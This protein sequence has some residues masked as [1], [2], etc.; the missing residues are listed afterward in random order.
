ML[1]RALEFVANAVAR[2]GQIL[3]VG[4][5]RQAQEVVV[6]E[7]K[8]S[9]QFHVTGRWL[10]GTL[11]NFRTMKTGIERL[12][13]LEQM[14]QDGT[15]D[16]L[17]KKEALGLRRERDRLEKFVGGIKD[18]TSMPAALFVIDPNH[19]HIA[20]REANRLAIPVIALTDTNC[21]PD[22]V[23]YIIPGNDDAIRSVKLVAAAVADACLFGQGRRRDFM[24]VAPRR[25][26]EGGGPQVEFS[27]AVRGQRPDFSASPA[28][29]EEPGSSE[30]ER[31]FLPRKP[32][33]RQIYPT[34]SLV[35]RRPN[36]LRSPARFNAA[37][38]S[39]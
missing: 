38:I 25:G 33:L 7:A 10:G 11:T 35:K 2:G 29:D 32:S 16:T 30:L 27:R 28:R 34:W 9:A 39:V 31:G 18:M 8:R 37:A 20:V 24:H 36:A 5:K 15:L 4:T 12:R 23:N 1:R 19:E 3:F 14:E 17:T 21:D 6:D 26:D 22:Q 13:E